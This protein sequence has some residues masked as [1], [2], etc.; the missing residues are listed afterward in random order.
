MTFLL[1]A[2]FV[3]AAR[4][5]GRVTRV[6]LKPAWGPASA[7]A[8]VALTIALLP[9]TA[10]ALYLEHEITAIKTLEIAS[11]FPRGRWLIV[12]PLEQLAQTYGRGWFEDPAT[13]VAKNAPRAGDP[14]FAFDMAVD[15]LFVFVERRPFKTFAYE[16]AD[17]P[18]STLADASY[19]QYRSLAGRASLQ[20]Q[21]HALCEAYTRTH[22]D[23]SIYYD[24]EQIRIYRFRVAR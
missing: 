6:D 3:L 12:A 23:A 20:A 2:S 7:A 11:D 24:D 18:F 16:A 17:V 9:R 21:V 14:S 5:L 15:D 13:F 19:R 4:Y 22:S 1:T 8:L 10:G